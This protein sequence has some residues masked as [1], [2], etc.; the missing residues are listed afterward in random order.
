MSRREAAIWA[1]ISGPA[2]QSLPSQVEEIKSWL[3][4][5]GWTVPPE[6]ILATD[7]ESTDI[8]R[9]TQMQILLRWVTNHEVGAVGSVHLDRFA[10]RPGQGAQILDTFRRAQVELLLKQTPLPP[11]I[12]GELMGLV[13]FVGKALSVERADEGAKR[14]L[15]DR[16][17]LRRVPVTYRRPYGYSWRQ[18]PLQLV[19]D[20]NWDIARFI[21]REGLAG[22]PTRA[23]VRKLRERGIPSPS[24]NTQWCVPTIVGIIKNP[25]YG[26]RFYAL[27]KEACEPS[28]RRDDQTYGKTSDRWLP[29]DSWEYLPEVGVVNA[30]ISWQEWLS[31]QRR[32]EQNRVLAKRN[33]KT[34][35]LLR[36][37][38]VC[39]VH[40]RRY[41]GRPSHKS[42][43]Y[44]CPV[45]GGH[46]F[47]FHGGFDGPVL[48]R[49]IKS[50]VENQVAIEAIWRKGQ[51]DITE[52]SL[53]NEMRRL[54]RGES[55]AMN[56]L[57][58]LERRTFGGEL[59]DEIYR[60]KPE[61]YQRL[62][63]QFEAK[64]QWVTD[65]RAELNAQLCNLARQAEAAAKLKDIYERVK[66]KLDSFTAHEW[67]QLFLDLGMAI[68]INENGFLEPRFEILLGTERVGDIVSTVPQ[69]G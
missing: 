39:N 32:L 3:E 53:R 59:A 63:R 46:G 14:G 42:Y 21:C 34:D 27:R 55:T 40:Q 68:H 37:L 11:G 43:R 50:I 51:P 67:R 54:E 64:L 9:C 25:L 29:F 33:S 7:W 57:V 24:G 30:P 35:Y 48:E 8:L 47:Y 18:N 1:R 60:I 65:R 61:I 58:E 62:K 31:V 19:P 38:L 12:M 56:A 44:E 69:H 22:T 66:D 6:R 28:H 15:L 13:I 16:P 4:A 41:S 23:I 10:A 5:Q 52:E 26:G 20:D 45:K 2:Q 49:I 36:A 17:K